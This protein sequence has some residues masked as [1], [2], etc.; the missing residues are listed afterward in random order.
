MENK[1]Q[2]DPATHTY[3]S[4]E[5]ILPSVT[6]IVT[7]V[8]GEPS[9]ASEWHMNRGR[10]VH[11]AIALTI[12]GTLDEST[13]DDRIRPY[14]DTAKKALSE[15]KISQFVIIETP[16]LHKVLQYA[17]TLDLF[18]DEGILIDFKTNQH[19]PTTQ[20]QLGGYSELL[21]SNGYKVNGCWELV[22][23]ETNYKLTKYKPEKCIRLFLAAY[24]LY[25]WQ[26][27]EK[28]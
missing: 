22:I 15:L 10:A 11:K 14:L 5:R 1:F 16:M 12:K 8:C 21:K 6:E 2:F 23:G 9:Y 13:I 3:L 25:G 17:G 26:K 28:R 27:E 4:G 24:T 20:I 18:T 19:S 7:S